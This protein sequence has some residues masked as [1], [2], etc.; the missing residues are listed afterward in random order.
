[1]T[2]SDYNKMWRL[3]NKK[4]ISEYNKNYNK[5]YK[6]EID[7]RY[8]DNKEEILLYFKQHYIKNKEKIDKRTKEY[9]HINKEQLSKRAVDYRKENLEH[10]REYTKQWRRNNK[11]LAAIQSLKSS[12]K[13]R[14]RTG[15]VRPSESEKIK[16][17]YQNCPDNMVVD[18]IIPL[19]GKTISG[20]HVLKNL[21]YLSARENM[22]KGNKFSYYPLE[23]YKEKGLI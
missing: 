10:R 1:M 3:K 8:Q 18:H 23:F 13:R 19:Q 9:N 21:Q 5:N 4:R 2:K 7:K 15:F 11:G 14:D 12:H 20:L 17:F 22:I 6:E 16:I